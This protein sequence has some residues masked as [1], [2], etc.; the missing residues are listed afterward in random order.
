MVITVIMFFM[1][2]VLSLS[3]WLKLISVYLNFL[4][5]GWGLKNNSHQTNLHVTTM[6]VD[7]RRGH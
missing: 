1:R 2:F 6:I 5:E 4:F 3:I 7:Y